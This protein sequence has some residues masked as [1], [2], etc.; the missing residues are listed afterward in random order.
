M[1]DVEMRSSSRRPI[2]TET[3]RE[4]FEFMNPALAVTATPR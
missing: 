3:P 4:V 2:S 1:A